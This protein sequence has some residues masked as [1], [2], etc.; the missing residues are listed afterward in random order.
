MRGPWCGFG[1]NGE[2]QADEDAGN[3]VFVVGAGVDANAA[4]C[5][6]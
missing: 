6:L 2:G 4:L 3:D 1:L 5:T